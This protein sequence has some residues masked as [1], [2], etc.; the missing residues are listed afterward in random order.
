L[1]LVSIVS[2]QHLSE[3]GAPVNAES[4]PGTSSEFNTSFN[5]GCPIQ[6]PDGLSF[7]MA[8]NRPGGLGGQD[9][10]V[11]RRAGTDDPW[12]APENLARPVP[13]LKG[14]P[15]SLSRDARSFNGNEQ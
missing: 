8:S 12:G 5:D 1:T 15:T 3:W 7:F 9:I 2:A 13:E 10:W 14:W 11:A 6:A 4:I